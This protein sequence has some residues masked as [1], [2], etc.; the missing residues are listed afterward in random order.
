MAIIWVGT[1]RFNAYIGPVQDY[2]DRVVAADVAVGNT[3]GLEVGVRDSYN[4]FITDA[5][6][7]GHLGSS[8]GVISQ[9]NSMIKAASILAGARTLAGSLV[10][11]VG[12]APTSIN[13]VDAD[14]NRKTGLLGNGVGTAS[15][16]RLNSNRLATA[17]GQDD[18]HL[19]VYAT[20]ASTQTV[21]YPIL[22]GGNNSQYC[23]GFYAS[24][25]DCYWRAKSATTVVRGTHASGFIGLS[26]AASSSFSA[27][28][29]GATQTLTSNSTAISAVP[30]LIFAGNN[31]SNTAFSEP[32]S[33]RISFYSIGSAIG[34]SLLDP[35]TATLM[36]SLAA[37]IP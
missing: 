32:S 23:I 6:D 35:R 13:F 11:L 20:A 7:T 21:N 5:L 33:P 34:L 24:N 12:P 16:K 36:A 37:A 8:G 29:G 25:K 30:V 2:I 31:N 17:D 28:Y 10:P 1:G 9:A 14:Y 22:I 19:A 18:C 27:R 4:V 15:N 26:R 3:Q